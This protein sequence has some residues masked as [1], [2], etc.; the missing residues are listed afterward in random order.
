MDTIHQIWIGDNPLPTPWTDTVKDFAKEYNY[1]YKLW[2]D[3][4]VKDLRMDDIPGL[5][6]VYTSFRGELAGRADILRLLILYTFGGIYIDADTVIMK[7]ANFHRFLTKNTAGVFF[8]WE[9]LTAA[10]TRKLGLGKIRRLVANGII[11]AEAGHPFIKELLEGLV[12]NSK[13]KKEAWKAVGPLY[14]TKQYMA[15]KKKFPDVHVYPM[16][17]FYPRAWAGITDPELHTKV[18][19][20]GA[21]MLFQYGYSTNHFDRI[22]RKNK[23][24]TRRRKH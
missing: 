22:F 13:G 3:A 15:L 6:A 12:E 4:S 2:T 23:G 5:K 21:S 16:R 20:P 10:R 17:Y 9:N 7:P 18:K 11:G 24:A 8:G 1:T 19:I 14:V